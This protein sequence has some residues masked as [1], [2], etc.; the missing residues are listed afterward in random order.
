MKYKVLIT[1]SGTGSRLGKL[2][3]DKNKSLVKVGDAEVIL[4]I[5]RSYPEDSEFIITIGYLGD[6]VR[7]FLRQELPHRNI[8]FVDVDLYEGKGSSLGYSLLKAEEAID[9]SFIFHCNDTLVFEEIP[10][11]FSENWIGWSRGKSDRLFSHD[12]Y[13][14]IK[15]IEGQV[16]KI[17]PKGQGKSNSLHI[18]LVG[19][20]DH[21][22]FF[23]DLRDVWKKNPLDASLN[24]VSAI[25]VMITKGYGF[26]A[27]EFSSWLDT[28]NLPSLVF[29]E[30]QVAVP[31]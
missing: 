30:S 8:T 24:D 27:K 18:G 20:A 28:G 10:I 16:S 26:A 25:N 21:Q 3:S 7:S 19:I 23:K 1:S 13:S 22:E 9:C 31:D 15:I 2:T 12:T 29:A 11:Y 5:I 17:Y 14:S 4:H 6:G